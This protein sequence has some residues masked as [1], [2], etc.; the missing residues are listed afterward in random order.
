MIRKAATQYAEILNFPSV[1]L[2]TAPEAEESQWQGL[3]LSLCTGNAEVPEI[4]YVI[5]AI[6]KKRIHVK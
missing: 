2:E 5:S 3:S 4:V 1:C 6:C